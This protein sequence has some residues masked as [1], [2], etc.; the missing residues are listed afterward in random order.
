MSELKLLNDEALCEGDEEHE[1]GLGFSTYAQVLADAAVGTTGPF[2]IGV[3]GEW[4]TGKT[5]LM[6]LI[7]SNLS[8]QEGVHTVWFNAWRFEQEEHPIIPLIA[9]IIRSLEKN[10]KLRGK[11]SLIKALRS[12]AYG[13]SVKSKVNI[14]GLAEIEASLVPKDIIDHFEKLS[15]DPLLDRSLYYDAFERISKLRTED[16]PRIVVLIDD[17]DRCFPTLAIR[18]LESIKLVLSQPG[19]IFILGVARSVIE[20]Y[21]NHRYQEEFGISD[22][23]GSLYLDK[24]VQ[25]PFHIPP[26]QKRMEEFSDKLLDR[27]DSE[28]RE[29][30][31][32]ILPVIAA[33]SGN[34]PRSTIRFVNNLLIDLAISSK[35]TKTTSEE[36]EISIDF[37]AVS[38]C[39][40][41]MWPNAF[42]LLMA[43]DSLCEAVLNWK[44]DD[45]PAKRKSPDAGR[46]GLANTLYADKDFQR[47]LT[48]TPGEKWLRIPEMRKAAVEFLLTQRHEEQQNE[49]RIVVPEQA[50]IDA[51]NFISTEAEQIF[52]PILSHDIGIDGEIEFTTDKGAPSGKKVYLSLKSGD[53]CLRR[54]SQDNK[55]I[56]D[57]K[58]PRQVMYWQ[59]HHFPVM[60]VIRT[61][62][63]D[64]RWLN[65]TEYLAKHGKTSKQIIF[66]GEPFTVENLLKM[67]DRT[68]RADADT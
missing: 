25:L 59:E 43:S 20:G 31:K 17:L 53:S 4:G 18:L 65:V 22:Y 39:L 51:V 38:R 67:R 45:Y 14:L 23:K 49:E 26:H 7:E 36:A 30:F 21:L 15:S 29:S 34:N 62:D 10:K 52:R 19:F 32:Q 47:L 11:A 44:P 63:G 2:T 56:F 60:L 40:Q 12:T 48:S 64:I 66:E 54:R 35:L 58:N 28:I 55:E 33:A 16:D 3:F 8:G 68:M 50:V 24:I 6:K 57:I 1:D 46:A 42:N 5:S 9:T 41:Q 61:S 13:F 37:F 27:I